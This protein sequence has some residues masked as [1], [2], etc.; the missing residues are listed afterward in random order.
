MVESQVPSPHRPPD[1]IALL[2]TH[3]VRVL[4][5]S[6]SSGLLDS[7]RIVGDTVALRAEIL[8]VTEDLICTRIGVERGKALVLDILH[9][10]RISGPG[11]SSTERRRA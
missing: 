11:G 3:S 5:N 6:V 2:R 9:P 1:E 8:Y 4:S 10:E 7:G